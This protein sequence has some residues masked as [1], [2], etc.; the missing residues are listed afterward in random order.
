[1]AMFK[2]IINR[3]HKEALKLY[4][5]IPSEIL[6]EITRGEWRISAADR[7]TCEY[8]LAVA[9]CI[10]REVYKI[11]MDK[12]EKVEKTKAYKADTRR[13]E[14]TTR[15]RWRFSGKIADEALRE[16]CIGKRHC[17]KRGH[18]TPVV[19]ITIGDLR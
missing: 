1:M 13:W 15:L 9:G 5:V 3:K 17:N 11:E 14:K 6:Y 2:F 16:K 4:K 7:E 10:V 12:W 18:I 19:P 8:A